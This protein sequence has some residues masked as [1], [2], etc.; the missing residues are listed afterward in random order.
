MVRLKSRID[1]V[2]GRISELANSFKE[3]IY[4]TLHTETLFKEKDENVKK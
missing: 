3:V 2:K 1:W 4:Y